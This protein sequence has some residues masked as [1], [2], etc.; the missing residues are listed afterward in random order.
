MPSV[1]ESIFSVEKTFW[2]KI[3]IFPI[4][5]LYSITIIN[6]RDIKTK[7][8]EYSYSIIVMLFIELLMHSRKCL[9]SLHITPT[10]DAMAHK[11]TSITHFKKVFFSMIPKI[12]CKLKYHLESAYRRHVRFSCVPV[13]HTSLCFCKISRCFNWFSVD[14]NV[15][16]SDRT[17]SVRSRNALEK[18]LLKIAHHFPMQFLYSFFE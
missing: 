17:Q 18:S 1:N 2:P 6:V 12:E 11:D 16:K 14:S 8:A 9:K 15:Q 4:S 5:N 10:F 7:T 3:L 13:C